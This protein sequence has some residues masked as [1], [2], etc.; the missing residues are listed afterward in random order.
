MK[1]LIP[2][3]IRLIGTD[4][5]MLEAEPV[6][7]MGEEVRVAGSPWGIVR[8]VCRRIGASAID[9][10]SQQLADAGIILEALQ[11]IREGSSSKRLAAIGPAELTNE[12]FALHWTRSHETGA[13][14]T[15]DHSNEQSN[16]PV[17]HAVSR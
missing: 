4:A 1:C 8:V 17:A 5:V 9:P 3:H 6:P 10:G 2:A 14:S 11:E 15:G 16:T 7:H 13:P 12:R